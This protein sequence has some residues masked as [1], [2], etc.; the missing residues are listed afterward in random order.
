MNI[1]SGEGYP[2]NSLSNFSPHPFVIDGVECSSMEGFLQSLK[3]KNPEVQKEVCKLV[4]LG[5][6]R[7][8]KN[9]NKSWKR[10]QTLYWGGAPIKRDSKE[11]QELLDRAFD[12]LSKN[13][14]FK[15]AL[16]ASKGMS[17]THSMGRDKIQDTT[18]TTKE[19]ISRLYKIRDRYINE[20]IK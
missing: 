9:R 16:L 18:L 11:Y 4:G 20:V 8:G 10:S 19:F 2:S 14:S 15:K 1:G 6:K 7:R 13:N 17:L 12:C 3:F 5:A